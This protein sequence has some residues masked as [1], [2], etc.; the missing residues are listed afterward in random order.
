MNDKIVGLDGKPVEDTPVEYD[1]GVVDL[2]E[3]CL[4]DVKQNKSHSIV[5]A[6]AVPT[7][8]G[9]DIECYWHGKRLTLLGACSRIAHRI[10]L[11]CDEHIVI[12]R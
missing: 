8:D 12:V 2:L 10:N 6:T 9:Y 11:Q 7:E 3:R 5:I 1:H 4:A